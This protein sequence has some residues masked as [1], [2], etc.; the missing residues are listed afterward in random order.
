MNGKDIDLTGTTGSFLTVADAEATLNLA[1]VLNGFD[2]AEANAAGVS[3]TIAGYTLDAVRGVGIG[4]ETSFGAA[5]TM[6]IAENALRSLD[7]ARSDI[8]SVTNQLTSQINNATVASAN[9]Q[10][11]ESGIRDVDFAAES[12]MFNKNKL[13]AQAGT[14]ALSQASS[15]EQNVMTLLQ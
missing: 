15:I 8:G 4:A 1:Q 3:N 12:A 11:A 9:I 13:L 5:I 7:A 6:D 10:I 14:F 2:E